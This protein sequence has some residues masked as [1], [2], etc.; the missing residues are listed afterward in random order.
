VQRTYNIDLEEEVVE[1][2]ATAN[3]EISDNEYTRSVK[4]MTIPLFRKE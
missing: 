1:V 4:A 3:S 2:I